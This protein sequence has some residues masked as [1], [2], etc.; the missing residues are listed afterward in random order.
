MSRSELRPSDHKPINAEK[1]IGI[2]SCILC[3]ST[4]SQRQEWSL[5]GSQG[6]G[7]DDL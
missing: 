2:V 7:L 5:E 4:E 1:K 6:V 3:L